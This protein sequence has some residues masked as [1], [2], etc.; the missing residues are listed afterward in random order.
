MMHRAVTPIV[1]AALAASSFAASD[2]L[3]GAAP[4]SRYTVSLP[5]RRA[6]DVVPGEVIVKF[7]T[8]LTEAAD[9]I[10]SRQSRF[11]ASTADGSDSLDRLIAE[12]G[13]RRIRPLLSGQAA[14]LQARRQAAAARTATVRS[15]FA[16]RS[17]R[18]IDPSLPDLTSAYVLE[19]PD[20][21]SVEQVAGRYRADPHVEYAHPNYVL[22][23]SSV[24]LP[25]VPVIPDD[26]YVHAPGSTDWSEGAWG[27]A[28]PDLW[29][30]Q[31]IRA[32]EAWNVLPNPLAD[33]GR[34]VVVAV[35][36]TGVDYAHDDLAPNVRTRLRTGSSSRLGAAGGTRLS[37]ARRSPCTT[38]PAARTRRS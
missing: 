38:P 27:Q 30:L 35:V 28:H 25:S 8:S 31:R 24:P 10:F 16:T 11:A 2:A 37:T 6:P 23:T 26:P 1:L 3:T 13:V 34:G 12:T 36:D 22:S 9:V 18:A 7:R 20:G 33:A 15:R 17:G 19:I 14:S 5:G 32:I 21:A 4:P 29:G